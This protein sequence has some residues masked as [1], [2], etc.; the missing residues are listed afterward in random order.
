MFL[1]YWS[2][3]MEAIGFYDTLKFTGFLKVKKAY[4]VCIADIFMRSIFH[5]Y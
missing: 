2:C 3:E 4:I 1:Y 5:L